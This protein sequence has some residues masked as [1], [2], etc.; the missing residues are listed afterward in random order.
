MRPARRRF[1][2]LAAGAAAF[3]ALMKH[4][5]AQNYPNRFVRLIVP[6]PPGGGMDP[7]ARPLAN[8]LSELWGQSVVI[9]NKAGGGSNIGTLAAAQS[10]PDGYTLLMVA[11]SFAINRSLYPSLGFDAIADFA[12]IIMVCSFPN[13]MTV[14]NSSPATS[15]GSFI[16]YAKVNRGRITFA[17]SG[18]GT[19]PHLAGELFKRMA[20]IEMTH[21]PYRGAG[22]A[23]NDLIPGRVDVMFGTMPSM[24]PQV[25]SGTLRGLAVTSGAR[26]S[27]AP[28]LPTIAESGLPGFDVATWYALFAPA[29]TPEA[30]IRKI[31]DDTVAALGDRS[32][33][34]RFAEMGAIAVTS[35]PTELGAHLRREIDKWAPIIREAGIKPE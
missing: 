35:T 13:L 14:P 5:T 26:S 22:P 20:G 21:V 11:P 31:H 28:E 9:E 3:P 19:A 8:R 4:A 24:L 16:D 27:F 17:S 29:R 10:A 18:I 33:K 2:H 1:L 7:V 34:Q 25:S 15:V 30:I 23:L 12:P 32:V 6:F